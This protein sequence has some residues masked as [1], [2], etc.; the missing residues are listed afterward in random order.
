MSPFHRPIRPRRGPARP[1]R[2][3]FAP[4]LDALETRTLLS[5]WL[6]N[7]AGDS[8]TG[9]LRW[10][11]GQAGSGDTID[12]AP[13]LN[14]QTIA[15]TGGVLDINQN[16]TIDG[17]GARKLAVSGSGRSGVFGV[18]SGA[19]V[20]ISGLTITDGSAS[21][22]GGIFNAGTLTLVN[23]NVT[24]NLAGGGS[25]PHRGGGLY[26]YGTLTVEGSAITDNRVVGG[27]SGG[28][29]GL[30][31]YGGGIASGGGMVTIT[32]SDI[33]DNS[34]VGGSKGSPLSGLPYAGGLAYGG[35]IEMQQGNITITG[36]TIRG[37][38]AIGGAAGEN[39][40][41][42]DGGVGGRAEGGGLANPGYVPG[43]TITLIDS[44]VSDNQA[45]GGA[46]GTAG[47]LGTGP[48]GGG[49]GPAIGGGIYN[50]GGA[51]TL[52]ATDVN[53]DRAFGGAGGLGILGGAGGA[54][55]GGGIGVGPAFTLYFN[56]GGSGPSLG[57]LVIPGTVKM[58]GGA[59]QSD[60]AQG[61]AGRSG[62][63]AGVGGAA[64]G[65]GIYVLESSL[66]LTDASVAGDAARGGAGGAGLSGGAGGTG[67]A[68]TG[69]GLYGA[70]GIEVL[71]DALVTGDAARGGAGGAGL[72]GGAGGA[73]SGG[74]LADSGAVEVTGESFIT[75]EY[76]ATVVPATVTITGALMVLDQAEGGA[77]GAGHGAGAGGAGGQGAGG[78]ISSG[79]GGMLTISHSALDLDAAV[80]G[81]G[82]PGGAGG[83]GLGG[84]LFN[85]GPS[86][87]YGTLFNVGY[88][89]PVGATLAGGAVTMSGVMV[90]LDQAQ[91]GARPRA[92]RP[93]RAS[94]AGSTW[95][96]AASPP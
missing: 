27:T 93:A 34:A 13:Q 30:D 45:I 41:G 78:A 7:S 3:R 22:G 56:F 38:Q 36:T 15:L 82:G 74:G 65:G 6:V 37:N 10:A 19:S 66:T 50:L 39:A 95:P 32:G 63:T 55:Q 9:S 46:G 59:V 33:S 60:A 52:V 24:G 62:A 12:F 14:G 61:G 29:Y 17:P 87:G 35:G 31:A 4:R 5:T 79:A 90:A 77:G 44:S 28:L 91:G 48:H 81:I 58:I 47:P 96:P 89:Q 16:I 51:L 73:G 84:A 42:S 71:T 43:N 75:G 69:G 18:S 86:V 2:R 8:G 20:T 68:A 49:G 23:A 53:G 57:V 85:A 72:S 54:A 67:G 70:G 26:N 88:G 64:Q 94:A 11:I 92:A 83:L 1:S 25:G 21:E 80:G 76:Y 40:P